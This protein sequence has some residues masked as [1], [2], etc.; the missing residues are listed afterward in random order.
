[1]TVHTKE[2]MGQ[3]SAIAQLKVSLNYRSYCRTGGE[4]VSEKCRMGTEARVS[5]TY[6]DLTL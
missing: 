6:R 2:A 5:R 3:Y 4:A 1:M